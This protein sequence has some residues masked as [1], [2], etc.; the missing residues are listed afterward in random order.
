MIRG[1]ILGLVA[2][3]V[4]ACDRADPGSGVADGPSEASIQIGSVD[5]VAE[6][7]VR[8]GLALG[9]HDPDY[10][11]AYHGPDEWAVEAK[12]SRVPLAE[13]KAEAARLSDALADF[14]SDGVDLRE[15]MLGRL[16]SSAHARIRMVEG[17]TLSFDEETRAL[18]DAVAPVYDIAEFDAALDAIDALLPGEAPLAARVDAFR[19]SLS[20]SADKRAAVF[21]AAIAACRERTLAHVNLP[22]SETFRL[23]FVT[24]KPWGG[25]NWYQG[26]F[27]SLIEINV[28][29]PIGIDR[30]VDLGCHEGYPG[31][32]FWNT[33]IEREIVDGEGWVEYTLYPL[34]SPLSLIAEG[35]ANFGIELA[36]P[37]EEKTI[38]ERDVL[39]PL[40]GLNPA[41]AP[42][43][44]E[45]NKLQQRLS[46]ARNFIARDYLDGR[47][48][49]AEA[50]ALLTK[51]GLTSP[52][53]A[54]KS[55]SF[56]ERYRGYVI[57]YNLGRD[58]VAAKIA[59]D[60]ST[61]VDPWVAF[62]ELLSSPATASDLIQ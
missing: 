28:D 35:S 59:R 39:F 45:L 3:G 18:Y 55:L 26:D 22:E 51:Y 62:L 54:E 48:A 41:D 49:R 46:H 20:I 47:I 38:F 52:E 42:K 19:A 57:N 40:A 12:A 58:I 36:F 23:E 5:E 16:L 50:V 56:V 60:V 24:D 8:L 43:L 4:A 6:R 34:F 44:A 29:L 53:R 25:Y 1:I 37:G 33:L 61:G 13:L 32:H 7:F 31:H 14:A 17:E 21:D 15:R 27:E 30:A 2:S 11:D 10:V 9:Q